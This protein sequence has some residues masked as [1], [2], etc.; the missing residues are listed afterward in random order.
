MAL[1]LAA[2]NGWRLWRADVATA[3]LQGRPQ[4]RELYAKVPKDA[5]ELMGIEPNTLMKFI[6]PMYGQVDAPRRWWP[7]A[8]DDLKAS[9]LKQLLLDPCRFLSFDEDGNNDG[10]NLRYVDDML[11]GGDRR[12]AVTIVGLS[13]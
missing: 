5:A 13:P 12:P 9:G 1:Q 6:K 8:V 7:R 11:G 2:N 4:E 10:F 3:F